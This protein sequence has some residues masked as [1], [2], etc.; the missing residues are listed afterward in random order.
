MTGP[1]GWQQPKGRGRDLIWVA[2]IALAVFAVGA[3]L[4]GRLSLSSPA[5]TSA[6]VV[7]SL[8]DQVTVELTSCTNEGARGRVT[9]H[10]ASTVGVYV[11][12][13]FMGKPGTVLDDGIDHVSGLRPGE[14]GLWEAGYFGT[15][16][17]GDCRASV[18]SVFAE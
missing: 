11:D 3:G 8:E 13:Q 5:R 7:R 6:P 18:S 15:Y 12:V 17:V 2:L 10:S 1:T 4:V 14:D 9:N 16:Q